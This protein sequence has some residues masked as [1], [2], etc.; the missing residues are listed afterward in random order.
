MIVIVGASAS[1]KT[2]L[3]NALTEKD[4]KYKKIITY[5]TRPKREKEV[6]GID[7]HFVSDSAFNELKKRDFF[8]EYASYNGWQYGTAKSDCTHSD[9]TIAI[10]TPSGL[11]N[12]RKANIKTSAIYLYVDRRSRLIKSLQRADNVDEA[13]RRNLSDLGQFDGVENEVDYI[14]ENTEYHLSQQ[15]VLSVFKEILKEVNTIVKT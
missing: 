8:I 10:L 1:G 5:T 12:L 2:T 4:K 3:V 9:Y 6:D 7:Y 14:I 11:R 15:Q 13:Y